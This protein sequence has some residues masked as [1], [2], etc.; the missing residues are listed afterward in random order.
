M[1]DK[2]N[3]DQARQ[4]LKSDPER[5]KE[6][7]QQWLSSGVDPEEL[8]YELLLKGEKKHYC[9]EWDYMAIDET[10]PEFGVCTCYD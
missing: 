9:P 5:T 6:L 2:I 1:A 3:W 10:V 8:T 7:L 4:E